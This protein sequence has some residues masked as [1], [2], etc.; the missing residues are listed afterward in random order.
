MKPTQR[1]IEFA[2]ELF[3]AYGEHCGWKN[4]QGNDMPKWEDVGEAV[5]SHWL[6]VA[7]RA[8]KITGVNFG[9]VEESKA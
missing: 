5:Q 2:V 6:A 9:I 3:N 8:A 4:F 1:D 7:E